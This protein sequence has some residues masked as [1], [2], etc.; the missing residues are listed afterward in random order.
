MFQDFEVPAPDV[1]KNAFVEPSHN[2][3]QLVQAAVLKICTYK[4]AVYLNADGTVFTWFDWEKIAEN[5]P[6]L[7][8]IYN[9]NG[10]LFKPRDI[11]RFALLFP[12]LRKFRFLIGGD[13][14]GNERDEWIRLITDLP[15]IDLG[16]K[17]SDFDVE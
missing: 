4:N 13:L 6:R 14:K 12:K 2:D 16:R 17:A 8:T 5:C 1:I 7:H 10:T 3:H 11:R 9:K 15:N